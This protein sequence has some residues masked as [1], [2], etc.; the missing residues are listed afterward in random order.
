M[1]TARIAV[2]FVREGKLLRCVVPSNGCLPTAATSAGCQKVLD[3][4]DQPASV[5]G[6]EQKCHSDPFANRK[7]FRE[8]VARVQHGS[9]RMLQHALSRR[10]RGK[11]VP[12]SGIPESGAVRFSL[13]YLNL[14]L[15]WYVM[16]SASLTVSIRQVPAHVLSV[17]HV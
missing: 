11:R 16:P 5:E 4:L 14:K 10:A 3:R 7:R 13:G 2:F 9:R 12:L 17:F 8:L 15:A 1:N 6:L